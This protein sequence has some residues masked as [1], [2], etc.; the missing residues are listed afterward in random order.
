M[1]LEPQQ[2]SYCKT[3]NINDYILYRLCINDFVLHNLR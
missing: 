3:K 1:T 2:F